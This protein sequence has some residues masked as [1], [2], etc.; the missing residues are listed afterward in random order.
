MRSSAKYIFW[1]IAITF[2]GGFLLAETSGLLGRSAVTQTTPVA[3]VNGEEIRYLTFQQAV[4]QELQGIQQQGQRSLTQDE[5]RQ[6]ENE[7]FDRMVNDI[8]LRQ[9]YARRGITVSD[10]EIREFALSSPPNWLTQNPELQT[11]GRFD[12]VKYQRLLSSPGAKQSGI[13]LQ[14]EGYYRSEIPRAKLF[15][16]VSAGLYV[17]DDELWR[18]WKDTHDS[19]R[20]SF[21]ALRPAQELKADASIPESALRDYFDKHKAGFQRTGRAVL[22]VVSLVR[23]IGAADSAAARTRA[24]QLRAEIAG[25]AK[26]EDVARRESSDSG[27]AAQGGD[28]GRNPP[29]RFVPEFERAAKALAPGQLSEPVLTQFGYHIIR[30]DAKQGDTLSLRHILVPI[31]PNDSSSVALDRKADELSR[32]AASTSGQGAKLDAVAKQL[33]LTPQKVVAFEGQPAVSNGK[34]VPSVSAWAFGGARPGETSELFDAEDGY[35]LARLDTLQEGGDPSFDKVKDEIRLRVTY[36]RTLD[37]L[38]QQARQLA[39]AA[40]SST[41]EQAAAAQKLEVQKSEPFTRAGFV[42]GIGQGNQAI[43]AAFGLPIGKVSQPVRTEEAI[44]VLRVDARTEAN[45]AQFAAQ[46]E[47]LRQQ[48]LNTLRQQAVQL[49]LQDLRKSAKIQDRRKEINAVTRRAEG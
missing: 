36:E 19:A 10:N 49:Y 11:E 27:S 28:L 12:P 34:V 37:R 48:R 31:R 15:D 45:K 39:T 47:L 7:V 24:Q 2:V 38:E 35:Y 18:G 32:Q 22:T 13:L 30:V 3:V 40:A 17:S 29:G 33:G 4:Q 9:E 46:K 42:P 8:L 14:L 21:V 5:T 1:F 26:F 44:Y 41:L 43:G 23:S 16:Q 6:V 20:V 25:G